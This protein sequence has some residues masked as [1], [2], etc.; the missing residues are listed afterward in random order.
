MRLSEQALHAWDVAVAIDPLQL[1]P[2]TRPP[3]D[4]R[5]RRR[6]WPGRAR[7]VGGPVAGARADNRARAI[8]PS[9]RGRIGLPR[10]R[11]CKLPATAGTTTPS[12]MVLPAEALLRLTAGRMDDEHMPAEVKVDRRDSRSAPA[13]VPRLLIGFPDRAPD[14][15]SH[16]VPTLPLS[17]RTALVTGANHGIG[18]AVAVELARLGAN[19]L[20]TYLRPDPPAVQ[21]PG[22]PDPP[23]TLSA[24]ATPRLWSRSSR[25]RIAR[26]RHRDRP[27]RP[28][29]SWTCVGCGTGIGGHTSVGCGTGLRRGRGQA[30][31]R[32]HPRQQRE[33]LAPGHILGT[34]RRP[35]VATRWRR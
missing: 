24:D 8:V 35:D 28:G 1:W 10:R 11:L 9:R 16:R 25:V 31:D 6:A 32:L 17:G 34:A 19:V 5:P 21:G 18:A 3:S 30:R 29:G 13:C 2:P 15:A 4:R 33:R 22:G 26:L 7:P 12:S 20:V 27:D 14:R 23:T